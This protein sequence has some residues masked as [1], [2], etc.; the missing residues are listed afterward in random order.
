MQNY[1]SSPSKI[2]L[3]Y[4]NVN[5][6]Y[7]YGYDSSRTIL[8]TGQYNPDNQDRINQYG[9]QISCGQEINNAFSGLGLQ[10]V[11]CTGYSYTLNGKYYNG[12][13]INMFVCTTPLTDDQIT[14]LNITI[15]NHMANNAPT[16]QFGIVKADGT[17]VMDETSPAQLEIFSTSALAQEYITCKEEEL[18]G[19][20]IINIVII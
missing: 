5:S 1:V 9:Q 3:N 18:I 19:A 13:D 14:L 6:G 17:Y 7:I 12:L 10:Y 4:L 15:A 11:F 16:D 20:T 8:L 2:P